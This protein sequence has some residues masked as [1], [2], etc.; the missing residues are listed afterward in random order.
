MQQAIL[1]T[2]LATLGALAATAVTAAVFA[3]A[4][5]NDWGDGRYRPNTLITYASAFA[6]ALWVWTAET[7]LVYGARASIPAPPI[8]SIWTL[9]GSSAMPTER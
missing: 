5:G 6:I 9:P 2:V 4:R 7:L 8:G 1:L 3:S